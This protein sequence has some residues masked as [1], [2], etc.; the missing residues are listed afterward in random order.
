MTRTVPVYKTLANVLLCAIDKIYALIPGSRILSTGEK[1]HVHLYPWIFSVILGFRN[2]FL[3]YIIFTMF[4][5]DFDYVICYPT[6]KYMDR[7]FGLPFIT[8]ALV[9]GAF[10][11]IILALLYWGLTFKE[12]AS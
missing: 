6:T 2:Y 7:M 5:R 10:L 12:I 9:G 8:V 11:L 1:Y 4:R 3:F